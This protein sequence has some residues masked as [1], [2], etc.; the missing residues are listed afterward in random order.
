M[1]MLLTG[2]PIVFFH[3]PA[4]VSGLIERPIYHDETVR[5]VDWSPNGTWMASGAYEGSMI[6]WDTIEWR[7]IFRDV[8]PPAGNTHFDGT[9]HLRFS[10]DGSMLGAVTSD[11]LIRIWRTMNWTVLKE[12]DSGSENNYGIEWNPDGT[13]IAAGGSDRSLRLWD[14]S[15]WTIY[16]EIDIMGGLSPTYEFSPN[17][18]YFAYHQVLTDLNRSIR[19][20]DTT[21]WE[22]LDFQPYFEDG[23]IT[24]SWSPDSAQLA[25]A[26]R[27]TRMLVWSIPS[28]D[29]IFNTTIKLNHYDITVEEVLEFSPDG[30][31]LAFGSDSGAINIW[32]TDKWEPVANDMG[33]CDTLEHPTDRYEGSMIWLL[34]WSEDSRYIATVGSDHYIRIWE[35]GTWE[36]YVHMSEFIEGEGPNLELVSL[37]LDDDS[38]PAHSDSTYF[39]IIYRNTGDKSTG[40]WRFRVLVNDEEE[41]EREPD[42]WMIS[43]GE[44][45]EERFPV[46]I[47]DLGDVKVEVVIDSLDEVKESDEKDNSAVT[48]LNV[49]ED[50]SPSSTSLIIRSILIIGTIIGIAMIVIL[51]VVSRKKEKEGSAYH[52]P[53]PPDR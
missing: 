33:H 24:I 31:Y 13:L 49:R 15:T 2:A 32:T 29:I 22:Y 45:R 36:E 21:N 27:D 35:E 6:I 16:R 12:F 11:G 28:G 7:P 34:R 41:L 40:K 52:G 10:P 18:R 14:T 4:E 30:K 47:N 1:I 8:F 20:L 51:A 43:P 23:T 25:A 5:A 48:H 42:N 3:D 53:P 19:V 46:P 39:K 9:R 17:G 37:E 38:N 50:T 26:I 44:V